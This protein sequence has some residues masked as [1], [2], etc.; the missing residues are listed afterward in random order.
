MGYKF[1]YWINFTVAKKEYLSY[2]YGVSGHFQQYFSYIVVVSFIGGGSRRTRRES[3]TMGKQLV[4]FITCGCKSS[5]PFLQLT[6]PGANPHSI[7]DRLPNSLSHPGPG[8]MSIWRICWMYN[9][10]LTSVPC[11]PFKYN[12][13]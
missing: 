2:G 8:K 9:S 4:S 7:G 5:A 10:C 11:F 6:K 12:N 1:V 3:P 13:C